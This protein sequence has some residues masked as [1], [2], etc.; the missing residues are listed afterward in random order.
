MAVSLVPAL[1]GLLILKPNLGAA[2]FLSRPSWFG[3][4]GGLA[5]AAVSFVVVPT[6]LG[7]WLRTIGPHGTAFHRPPIVFGFFG[8]LLLLA[9]LRWRRPE[10]RL[11]LL[12]ACVPQFPFFYDQLPLWLVP[13]SRRESVILS[14]FS[15]AAFFTWLAFSFDP[16]MHTVVQTSPAPFVLALIYIPC[17]VMVLLR[18]NEAPAMAS[19]PAAPA[20][21]ALARFLTRIRT[22]VQR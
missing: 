20:P 6:W 7:D 10:A 19:H 22:A 17:L 4:A 15:F 12:M 1:Q 9:A 8:P 13:Q 18:P 2:L 11:L 16:S 21:A 5:V 3:I 14:L